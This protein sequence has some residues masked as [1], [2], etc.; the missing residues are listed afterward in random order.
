MPLV[1]LRH[2]LNVFVQLANKG[3]LKKKITEQH[4]FLS[5]SSDWFQLIYFCCLFG[6]C[7]LRIT[8]RLLAAGPLYCYMLCGLYSW[9]MISRKTDIF[10]L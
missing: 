3:G 9:A 10:A 4:G 8:I 1:I 7:S 6:I 5:L 2:F